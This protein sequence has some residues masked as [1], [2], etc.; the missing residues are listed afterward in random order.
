M[1]D[2]RVLLAGA[3][4]VCTATPL[5]A[6]SDATTLRGSYCGTA[7]TRPDSGPPVNVR[8]RIDADGNA[9]RAALSLPDSWLLDLAAPSPYS[10]STLATYAGDTLRV[11]YTP[12]IGLGFISRLGLPHADERITLTAWRAEKQADLVGRIRITSYESSIVL[13]RDACASH[14]NEVSITFHSAQDSLHLGGKLVIPD[15]RAPFPAVVFVTG[16][17]PDTRE[18]WQLVADALAAR[19]IASLLYD[20]RGVGASSGASHDLASWDDLAGDVEGAL[21][22]LRS[23]RDLIDPARIGLI[24][25]SQGTWIIAKVA[26]RDPGVRFLVSIAGSGISA[27][28][29]ETYRTGALMQAD[30]FPAAEVDAARAFQRQKFAVASSGIGWERLDS[31]MQRLRADSVK[32]FP[33]YGTGA[34]ARSL[35]VLR[36]YGVLQF[37]YDPRRDLERITAPTI[38]IMGE[39]DLVFPP[40]TVIERMTRALRHAGNRDV[41]ARIIPAASHGLMVVQTSAG[42]PFRRV[43]SEEFIRTLVDWVAR[44]TNRPRMKS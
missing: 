2:R 3:V 18:A 41:T 44:H 33:G 31:A 11:D 12:D 8:L 20:K 9:L 25:Q 40:R 35:A 14:W 27:A 4:A 17:D 37:N 39:R 30:G 28:E 23:R 26:G 21:G 16:S 38:I 15:G 43:V 34:G 19:G 7:D 13:R 1:L 10:D 42:R 24:G 6:Q 5:N 22:Y 29:Q 36:L 32:W